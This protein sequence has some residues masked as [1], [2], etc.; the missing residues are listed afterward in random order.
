MKNLLIAITLV[1]VAAFATPAQAQGLYNATPTV[2]TEG[3]TDGTIKTYGPFES[4]TSYTVGVLY[5]KAATEDSLTTL[6]V[7]ESFSSTAAASRYGEKVS[8]DADLM[9]NNG[10]EQEYEQKKYTATATGQVY[11]SL[12]YNGNSTA[13]D[14]LTTQV[15]LYVEPD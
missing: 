8:A 6:E 15:W 7:Y 5:T 12:Y 3:S 9:Y 13:T 11:I 14:T 2:L 4:V 1:F 10:A